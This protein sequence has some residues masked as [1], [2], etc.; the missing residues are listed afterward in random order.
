MQN[1]PG[2]RITPPDGTPAIDMQPDGAATA[3]AG[4]P[5]PTSPFARKATEV[6]ENQKSD[7]P[8]MNLPPSANG[9]PTGGNPPAGGAVVPAEMP[10]PNPA[11]APRNA[12]PA[13]QPPN[14]SSARVKGRIDISN[15]VIEKV[16]AVAA[17]EVD[18][19]AD[20]GSDVGNALERMRE[21]IGI[22]KKDDSGGVGVDMA[23][24]EAEIDVPITVKY[25]HAL[26]DVGHRVQSNVAY[27]LNHMLGLKITA[28]NV[29]IDDI[30][31][32]EDALSFKEDDGRSSGGGGFSIST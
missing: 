4:T 16:A 9:A 20:L 10:G 17:Y 24:G 14:A 1:N 27:Q 3:A 7:R 2:G 18:G 29:T 6:V 28:V 23:G 32:P 19:V 15:E 21:R 13:P 25:G 5:T 26:R 30:E 11:A 22:G 31:L 12:G 8:D